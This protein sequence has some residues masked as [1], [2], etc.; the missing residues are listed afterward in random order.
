MSNQ[1]T[2]CAHLDLN[3][4]SN[5]QSGNELSKPI[6]KASSI[7]VAAA[8]ILG[9]VS[10]ERYTGDGDPFSANTPTMICNI[11]PFRSPDKVRWFFVA[12]QLLDTPINQEVNG[13]KP[14]ERVLPD[15]NIETDHGGGAFS[16]TLTHM[17]P[18]DEDEA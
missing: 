10:S 8:I 1:V 6:G 16:Q 18:A 4:I 3:A 9:W 11:W 17:I 5:G 12:T 7:E 14:N 13:L 2:I 15:G